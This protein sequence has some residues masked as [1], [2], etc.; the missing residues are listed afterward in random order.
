VQWLFFAFHSRKI[1]VSCNRVKNRKFLCYNSEDT[2]T[3]A[4]TILCQSYR[5]Q[6]GRLTGK[7]RKICNPNVAPVEPC[8]GN[9]W[10]VQGDGISA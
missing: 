10:H 9:G 8:R 4:G 5:K 3:L 1:V 2:F 7:V 6:S